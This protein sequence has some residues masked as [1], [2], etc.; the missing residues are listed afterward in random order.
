MNITR[1]REERAAEAR[2]TGVTAGHAGAKLAEGV[3]R[4]HGAIAELESA[5][6]TIREAQA[7]YLEAGTT[8]ELS[9]GRVGDA[10]WREW[11]DSDLPPWFR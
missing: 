2:A 9:F 7:E 4:A 6:E 3:G 10:A 5:F 8:M 11:T 1:R